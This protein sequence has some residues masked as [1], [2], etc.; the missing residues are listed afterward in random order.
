M[1]SATRKSDIFVLVRGVEGLNTRAIYF[2][3][4]RSG[5]STVTPMDRREHRRV[6]MSLPVRLRWAAPLGQ[7]IELCETFDAS[8]NGLL[9]FTKA[10]HVTGVPLWVT[11]PYDASPPDG[12]P[13]VLAHVVRSGERLEV[14]RGMNAREKVQAQ[15][16][17]KQERSVKL[18]QPVRAP[19][20]SD[21]PASFAVALHFEQHAHSVSNG[22][23]HRREPERR[24]SPRRVLALPVRVRPGRVPWFEEAMAIDF[25]THGMCFRSH[26]EYQLGDHL[27]I[28]FADSAS[29]PW[30][31]SREFRTMVV[32]VAPV[33][34]S[35]A[36]D[37]SVCRIE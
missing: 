35:F 1:Q 14:I 26:R 28:A 2:S 11:F 18:D 23:G 16:T 3:V 21:A 4:S 30:S 15:S 12:Q 5:G 27:N 37:V 10:P 22:N 33:P 9:V 8:R 13:E 29:A 24:R 36:L 34:D 7:K 17:S 32:R 25:S 6:R 19:G 20:T 31:G